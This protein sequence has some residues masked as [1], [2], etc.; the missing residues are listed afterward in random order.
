MIEV[1]G[2]IFL[3]IILIAIVIGLYMNSVISKVEEKNR[4]R[5]SFYKEYPG[6]PDEKK[7]YHG[8][9]DK[10]TESAWISCF[11]TCD[12]ARIYGIEQNRIIEEKAKK[13]LNAKKKNLK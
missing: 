5:E 11:L 1:L 13:L 6:T 8:F 9:P 12:E 3:I 2:F 7:K 10:I 4:L